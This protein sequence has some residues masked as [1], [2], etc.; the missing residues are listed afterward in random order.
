MAHDHQRHPPPR[1]ARA[2]RLP[3][4]IGFRCRRSPSL[5]ALTLGIA[6]LAALAAH[7]T[8]PHPW[9]H[10]LLL[11]VALAFLAGA[12]RGLL[13]PGIRAVVW[14]PEGGA[15]ITV[16]ASATDAARVVQGAV[17]GGRVLGPLIVLVL[18]WPPRGRA[19]LWLLPDNLDADTRRRLRMRL[20][21]G[22]LGGFPSADPDSR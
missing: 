1:G 6:L 5:I 7:W 9:L 21:T 16:R 15:D 4:A 17:Q 2:V 20:G 10:R 22:A 13:R 19:H 8:G 11:L 12:L 14:R 3:P 18:R